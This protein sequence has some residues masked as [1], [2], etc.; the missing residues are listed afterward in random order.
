MSE[1]RT[2]K[3]RKKRKVRLDN[4]AK[5]TAVVN[6]GEKRCYRMHFDEPCRREP[7]RKKNQ[8]VDSIIL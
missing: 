4:S 6:S 5:T 2:L 3:Q 1:I 8:I 7:V